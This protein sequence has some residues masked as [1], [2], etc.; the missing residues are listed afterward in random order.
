MWNS[1]LLLLWNPFVAG[2]ESDEGK[3]CQGQTKK[4]DK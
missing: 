1:E 2:L 3:C 4:R